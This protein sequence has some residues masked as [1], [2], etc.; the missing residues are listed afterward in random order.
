MRLKLFFSFLKE[1][2]LKG[3]GVMVSDA[4]VKDGKGAFAWILISSRGMWG[5]RHDSDSHLAPD[6]KRSTSV[7]VLRQP[8]RCAE[9]PASKCTLSMIDRGR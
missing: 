8:F 9:E 7:F 3:Q 6:S 4:S 2:L 5:K 1:V